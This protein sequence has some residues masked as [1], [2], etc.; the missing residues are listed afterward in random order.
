[1]SSDAQVHIKLNEKASVWRRANIVKCGLI[2]WR[3][4]IDELRG[5]QM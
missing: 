4:F 5:A 1:M 3:M 2:L